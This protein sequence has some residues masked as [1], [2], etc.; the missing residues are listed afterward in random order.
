MWN[1]EWWRRQRQLWW[2]QRRPHRVHFLPP[3]E[4]QASPLTR[5]DVAHNYLLLLLVLLLLLKILS[6]QYIRTASF[7]R[8]RW[9]FLFDWE[10][11]ATT[12]TTTTTI[13]TTRHDT[14]TS[15]PITRHNTI[16]HIHPLMGCF[17]FA[18]PIQCAM[19]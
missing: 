13:T 12:T 5:I 18:A 4:T 17:F 10:S 14:L 1:M 7:C 6:S 8:L 2:R 3:Q 16:W 11:A 19:R 9:S 15:K